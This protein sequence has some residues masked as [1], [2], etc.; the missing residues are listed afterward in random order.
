MVAGSPQ[1]NPNF[2]FSLQ[3]MTDAQLCEAI[4]AVPVL[5]EDEELVRVDVAGAVGQHHA[6]MRLRHP[7][8]L[9][10]DGHLGD[11]AFAMNQDADIRL[12]GSVRHGV[13]EGMASG[14]V[15]VQGD[16]GVGAGVAMTGGT[17]AIF[18]NA[19]PRCGAAMRSGSIFVR[20]DVG[21]EA[22]IGAIGGTIVIGGNAGHRLGDAVNNVSVFIRGKALSLAEGVTEAPLRKRE[23]LRLGLLLINASIRGDAKEFRRIV[24]TALLQAENA[25]RG[26][27]TPNWR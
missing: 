17:L 3:S 23:E 20:G 22:G 14:A 26:E 25:Q 6:M 9:Q 18:G 24:P 15:R 12:T 19:G 13:A 7:V 21:D 27:V 2:K 4:H 11:Y 5:Q 16:A 8:R 10:V 1:R